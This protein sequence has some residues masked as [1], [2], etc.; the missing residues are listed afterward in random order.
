MKQIPGYHLLNCSHLASQ[1]SLFVYKQFLRI[2]VLLAT[3]PSSK[4][5][6][7]PQYCEGELYMIYYKESNSKLAEFKPKAPHL[8]EDRVGVSLKREQSIS[9]L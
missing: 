7:I 6:F 1:I 3:F 5:T 2:L 9:L 4:L 8:E